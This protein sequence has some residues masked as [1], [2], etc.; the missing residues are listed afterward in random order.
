MLN[1]LLRAVQAAIV[2]GCVVLTPAPAAHA[3]WSLEK[4]EEAIKLGTKQIFRALMTSIPQYES[5]EILD[6]IDIIVRR[7]RKVSS[8]VA[9]SAPGQ[10]ETAI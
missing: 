9:P 5:H 8:E 10:I 6:N 4:T 2:A 7:K 1:R 3:Q